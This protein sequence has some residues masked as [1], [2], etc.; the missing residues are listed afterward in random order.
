MRV[1]GFLV[2]VAVMGAGCAT[3]HVSPARFVSRSPAGGV[4][5][6]PRAEVG[7]DDANAMIAAHCGD[8]GYA[9]T[10]EGEALVGSTVVTEGANSVDAQTTEG[11]GQ[12]QAH[13]SS[14]TVFATGS[15][16]QVHYTCNDPSTVNMGLITRSRTE[17]SKFAWGADVGA[18]MLVLSGYA[19]DSN[20]NH[21]SPRNGSPTAMT[22]NVWLGFKLSDKFTLGGG[23]GIARVLAM[24]Q[25]GYQFD[26]GLQR[27]VLIERQS[28]TS[29]IEFFA[30]A[31]YA[32]A[33]R[34]DMGVRIGLAD[35][36]DVDLDGGAPFA[37]V[38]LGYRVLDVGPDSGVYVA[39]AVSSYF[40]SS[41]TNNVSPAL[42]IG[43][44]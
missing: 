17:P 12:V 35:W 1:V 42:M 32:V 40:S 4:V 11:S 39:G 33:P 5:A 3:T 18:G 15:D 28:D 22:A 44:H 6:T 16:W 27:D 31:R 41:L 30:T 36:S 8:G 23:V 7:M 14:K 9:I 34:L 13:D 2:V 24:P 37:S 20:P 21:R 38:Q 26:N 25:W 19:M 29:A 10:R 43:F